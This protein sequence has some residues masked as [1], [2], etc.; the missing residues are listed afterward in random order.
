LLIR[1]SKKVPYY[2]EC[3]PADCF[4][5]DFVDWVSYVKRVYYPC[6]FS[7][8]EFSVELLLLNGTKVYSRQPRKL[9]FRYTKISRHVKVLPFKENLLEIFEF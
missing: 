1:H 2:Q 6:P 3:P 7:L 9:L 5:G 4:F 8:T